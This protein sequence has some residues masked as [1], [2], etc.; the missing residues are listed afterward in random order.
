MKIINKIVL[1]TMFLGST[2]SGQSQDLIKELKKLTLE[3]DSLK[4]QVIKPIK[5]EL[6]ESIEK[7]KNEI[8]LLKL[9]LK[10]LENDSL[11]RLKK[12]ILALN[13]EIVELN[14]NKLT[15]QNAKLQDQINLI[16]E[17][18]NTINLLNQKNT[19]LLFD[20][21]NQIKE[22]AI[23]EKENGKK[24]IITNIINYYKNK[25]IDE[26]TINSTKE[27][28]QQ[29]EQ[30]I[31]TKSEVSDIIS[32][33]QTYFNGKEILNHKIDLNQLNGIKTKL[34]IIKKES[35]LIKNLNEKLAN[36]NTLSVKLK[37]TIMNILVFDDK[38]SKKYMIGEGIDKITRQDKLNKIYSALLPY[39]YDY[40]IKYN[41]YPYLFD[42]ILDVIKR[43]QSNTDEDISDLLNKI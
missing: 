36:Y 28:I 34:N 24:E 19:K 26:I 17:K 13:K 30:I 21:E 42:I 43:K 39:V 32:D 35:D 6:K 9:K 16:T 1:F 29:D 33:I 20:K 11:V 3:N 18:S 10:D 14:K 27:S 12:K 38:S 5:N 40:D 31:G 23:K 25:K 7:N 8:S 22:I 41:D 15:I 4:S 2:Y 37:E